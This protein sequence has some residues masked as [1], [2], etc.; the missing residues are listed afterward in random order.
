MKSKIKKKTVLPT[1]TYQKTDKQTVNCDYFVFT[2]ANVPQGCNVSDYL[3]CV[4]C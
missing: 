1:S 2:Y 3:C 4:S